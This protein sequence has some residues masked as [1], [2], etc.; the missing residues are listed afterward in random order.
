MG[1]DK[2][3]KARYCN[4]SCKNQLQLRAPPM[5][6]NQFGF[7]WLLVAMITQCVILILSFPAT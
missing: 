3:G 1:K 4:D 2:T 7:C 5:T 6:T